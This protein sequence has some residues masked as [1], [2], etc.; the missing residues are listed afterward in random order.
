MITEEIIANFFEGKCD[1]RE[2]AMVHE[3][4]RENPAKLKEYMGVEEWED[5]QPAR[6]LSP[7]ISGK[8]WKGI[9]K[10]RPV[11]HLR[12]RWAAVAASVVL[13]LGLS[14][15][16]VAKNQKA[17]AKGVVNTT[18]RKMTLAL[19]DGSTVEL[20]PNSML[21]YPE[22]FNAVS[23][24]VTLNG[25]AIFDVAKDADKPFLVHSDSLLITV[26]G[27][28]FTVKS[29][30][31]GNATKVILH[32]GSVMVKSSQKEYYLTP[33]DIFV[34]KQA[35]RGVKA[36]GI[37]LPNDTASA[38]ILHLEKDKD[39]G[40]V[41]NDYPLDVVFDQLQIIYH[42]KITYNKEGLGN[43]TF[44]GRTDTRDS[45]SHILKSIALLNNFSMERQGDG[46]VIGN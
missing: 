12:L 28:R 37:P 23:R 34:F 15:I 24:D 10:T 2:A 14:W 17:V 4:L 45:L 35:S 30:D 43:R 27:T 13:V 19:S 7:D 11:S 16:I 22:N 6:V 9:S 42:T 25:E 3:W 36:V 18:H 32:E 8:L 1:A 41:F 46:F 5:F 21:T 33:G 20:M 31:A 40:Y 26:L 39:G 29:Y 38:R 44:I